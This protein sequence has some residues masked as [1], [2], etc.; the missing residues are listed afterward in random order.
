MTAI[1]VIIPAFRAYDHLPRALKSITAQG[2]S[3]D[4]LEVVIAPDD[5]GDYTFARDFW[6]RV[7]IA[8]S[9]LRATGPGAARN[10]AIA[11][12]RGGYLAFLDADDAW[13]EGYLNALLPLARRHGLAFAPTKVNTAEGELLIT[14]GEGLRRL[15]I[16]D[17]GHWP[18]SFHPL[19]DR[20]ASPGFDD[21]AG[22]DVRHAMALLERAGRAAPMAMTTAYH[23]HLSATSVTADPAFARRID[24]RY[25]QMI[26]AHQ[27]RRTPAFG[28][29]RLAAIHALEARRR[30]NMRFLASGGHAHGFYGM[31]ASQ[32][33]K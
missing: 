13:G 28:M 10:R 33:K 23:L 22:Q 9:H 8:R 26:T 2:V 31:L 1:S 18:G 15:S 30:W 16:A 5:G 25:R 24:R 3:A 4:D 19:V 29:G 20:H 6:P 12:A 27:L 32:I 21:G 11:A 17:F 7:R 14:L